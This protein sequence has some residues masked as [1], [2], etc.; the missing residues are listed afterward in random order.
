LPGLEAGGGFGE[1]GYLNDVWA[2]DPAKKSVIIYGGD[3]RLPAKFHDL[4]ELD[5]NPDIPVMDMLKIAGLKKKKLR[6]IIEKY[7]P[8]Q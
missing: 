2:F 7:H 5:I 3:A 6:K 8:K 4:W 1:E